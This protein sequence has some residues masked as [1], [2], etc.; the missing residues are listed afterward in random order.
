MIRRI[1]AVVFVAIWAISGPVTAQQ[2]TADV[3]WVQIEA[4]PSLSVAR[5]RAEAYAARL[6]DVNGFSLGGSWY[7]IVLG[8]YLRADAERL[9]RTYRADRVIPRDSYIALSRALGAQYWPEGA[10]LLDRGAIAA[11]QPAAQPQVTE[12]TQPPTPADE[13]PAQARRSERLL[14]ADERKDLQTALRAAGYYNSTIDGAFGAGTRRS[15]ADWQFGNGYEGTGILTTSQRIVLMDQY[16]APLISVGMRRVTDT[17]AGIEIDL[18]AGIV[19]FDRYEPPFAHYEATGDLK[20][21]V[22]LIS[23]TGT[24]AT[25]SG[26]YDIMQTLKI[27]PLDG[28]R[29]RTKDRFV[30]EGRGN[31]FVSHTEARLVD[32]QIKGFTLIWP[33]DDE[34]RRSRVLQAMQSKFTRLEGTLDPAAGGD[35]EQTIARVAGLAVR[36]PRVSR[37]GFYTDSS[38][39][40]VTTADAI[41]GCTRITLGDGLR[42]EVL[43]SDRALGVAVL[44]PEQTLA[45]MSVAQFR[46]GKGRLKSEI[47]VSGFSYAGLLGAPTLTFG[48]VADLRGLSGETEQTRLALNALPGDAG[49]PVLDAQGGVLGM[50]LADAE[51]ARQ[52][53]EN[54]SL[55]ADAE[56]ISALLEMTDLSVAE[57]AESGPL[58]PAD[59]TRI[60]TG[61]TVLVNCWD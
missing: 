8:P 19:G 25:L 59:M 47:V 9:L 20:A 17:D 12:T 11:P 34:A 16:N 58:A 27:V 50:L 46:P 21:K 57:A 1:F 45:P 13:T 61:M 31:G 10:N 52:L 49:G 53:P 4:H 18:P 54:V 2:A 29:N 22:L 23:Q 42:A 37:S 48:T 26:L 3:V 44:R 24:Q 15:M 51:Q 28:P 56:A 55:V 36:K 38:G 41:D 5:Q 33:L 60:A 39:T 7:G 14:S 35:A 32:G 43:K 40:V 6:P 30:L